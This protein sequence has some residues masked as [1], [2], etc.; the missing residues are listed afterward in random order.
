MKKF[1][2]ARIDPP[3]HRTAVSGP[4][5][6]TTA[7]LHLRKGAGRH[8]ATQYLVAENTPVLLL[9][10]SGSWASVQHEETFG[11]L[12]AHRLERIRLPASRP[13]IPVR[14]VAGT[15]PREASGAPSSPEV[16]DEDFIPTHRSTAD[17]NL[18]KGSGTNYP[19]LRVLAANIQ[20]RKLEELGTWSKVSTG[21]DIGWVPSAYLARIHVQRPPT[22][23]QVM[24]ATEYTTTVRLNVRKDAGDHFPVLRIMQA[25]TLVRVNGKLGPWRRISLDTGAGWV[26]A[27]QLHLRY[28][29]SE[30]PVTNT[31]TTLYQG[32]SANYRALS[33][34]QA[35]EAVV[36]LASRGQ[37][38]KV[39]AGR[40]EGWVHSSHLG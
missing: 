25:G 16:P 26:P 33:Q 28:L 7:E 30:S 22:G 40:L 2:S 31:S 13:R 14:P 10:I 38:T 4:T 29:A 20:V 12:P 21:R 1:D 9:R 37:W 17:L 6:R 34:L 18:R 23:I 11:W 8:Y 24:T 19:V 5:H 36:V 35:G 39:R 3:A 15:G 32:A 27:S